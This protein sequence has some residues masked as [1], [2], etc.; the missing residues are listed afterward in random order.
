MKIYCQQVDGRLEKTK[1]YDR[2]KESL[3][4]E[5][6]YDIISYRHHLQNERK[7]LHF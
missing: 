1:L 2:V 5:N 4:L 7:I 3:L 6:D